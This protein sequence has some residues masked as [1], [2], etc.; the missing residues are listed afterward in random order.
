MNKEDLFEGFG[1]LDDDLLRR[2]EHRG[3]RMKKRN[4][5]HGFL[6][7]GSI[8]ACFVAAIVAGALFLNNKNSNPD[9]VPESGNAAE[10]SDNAP[11]EQTDSQEKPE[12]YVNISM[13]LASH[14]GIEAQALEIRLV[15]I[16]E[17]SACYH[18]VA[19]AESDIL[20][21]SIGHEV[22]GTENWY[23]V[24]GH[25][26]MQYLISCDK[27][28]Y[29]LWKFDVFQGEDYP[30]SDVLQI[31]YN[32][33]AA[34]DIAKI[35]VSPANMDNSDAGKAIQDEIGTSIVAD[36]NAIETIYHV[37]SGLTCYGDNH[38][39][40][41]GLGDDTPSS[42]LNQVR[43]GRYLTIVTSQGMEMDTLKYT[44]ISGMFYEYGGIAYSALTA[45]EKAAVENILGIELAEETGDTTEDVPEEEE[46]QDVPVEGETQ[47]IPAEGEIYDTPVNE[48][49]YQEAREYSS[50][51]TDLQ[52]RISEAMVNGELPFVTVSA[53]YENPDRLHVTVNTTEEAFIDKLLAFDT[54][55]ELLEIEYSESAMELE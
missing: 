12:K 9:I 2:S 21:E 40:K 25:E 15:E 28:E 55:G 3:K 33:H 7:Y 27:E 8:A 44:G 54:T 37:L 5:F 14:G 48:E 52:N 29:S 17:Y 11:D 19:S 13:L 18:K 53:I 43:A 38:W 39:D 47:D 36:D 22:Q 10:S 4:T 35:I 41:I 1:A 20:R 49:T 34:E 45:E 6:K 26:D 51:L 24:S 50:A 16:E 42:M 23:K 46:T 32:I 30:Y 31:I